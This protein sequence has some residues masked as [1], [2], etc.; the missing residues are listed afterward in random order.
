MVR[1]RYF[2]VPTRISYQIRA[3][4]KTMNRVS[5][6]NTKLLGEGSCFAFNNDVNMINNSMLE[7]AKL[8]REEFSADPV[9]D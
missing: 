2:S 9:K 8:L 6:S 7:L 1:L 3:L 5:V 4:Y